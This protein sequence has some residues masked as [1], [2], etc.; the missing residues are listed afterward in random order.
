MRKKKIKKE[1]KKRTCV[2]FVW[3]KQQKVKDRKNVTK[4]MKFEN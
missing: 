4:S 2:D 3:I 1:K